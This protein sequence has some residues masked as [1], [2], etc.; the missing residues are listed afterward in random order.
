MDRMH[1]P[2]VTDHSEGKDRWTAARYYRWVQEKRD[3]KAP[4]AEVSMALLAGRLPVSDGVPYWPQVFQGVC[5]YFN[6]R[7]GEFSALQLK[8]F[9]RLCGGRIAPMLSVKVVTHVVCENLSA[10]K[11][12]KVV[13]SGPKSRV[14]FVRPEWILDSIKGAKRVREH[15]YRAVS[16]RT[17]E[18]TSFFKPARR[19]TNTLGKRA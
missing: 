15:A 13:A 2:S 3:E 17:T 4:D 18:I 10:I 16:S 8:S 1:G 14:H 12:A 9:V 5:V 11:S 6:G 19:T 7:S